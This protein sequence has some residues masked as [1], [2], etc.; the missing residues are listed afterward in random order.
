MQGP[1]GKSAAKPYLPALGLRR[2][3]FLAISRFGLKNFRYMI[4]LFLC[5]S[6]TS[7]SAH[8]GPI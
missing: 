8:W 2:L 1:F 7:S 4:S 3:L 5:V 6:Q